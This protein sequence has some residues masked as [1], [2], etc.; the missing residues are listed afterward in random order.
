MTTIMQALRLE[1]ANIAKLLD[2]LEGQLAEG[3]EADFDCASP[4][5]ID[6]IRVRSTMVVTSGGK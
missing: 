1:H 4:G 3:A 2:L 5:A 6:P